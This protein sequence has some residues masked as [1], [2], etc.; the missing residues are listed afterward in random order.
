MEKR[1]ENLE[2]L[3][4]EIH[5]CAEKADKVKVD[6]IMDAV[7]GRSFGPLLL[8]AGVFVSAPG[9]ADIPGVPTVIGLFVLTISV[10]LI[11]GNDHFWL[12]GWLLDRKIKSKIILKM[13]G[14][15]WVKKPAAFIDRLL[16]ERLRFLTGRPAMIGIATV[17]AVTMLVMPLTEVVPLS[18]NVVGAGAIAFGLS[19]IAKDGAMALAGFLISAAAVTLAVAGVV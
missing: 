18:A 12:P 13:T 19:L 16:K 11:C 5:R 9:I 7:G 6:D 1:P 14:S 10:Q 2:E 3:L 17:T 8:L 4:G 15:K